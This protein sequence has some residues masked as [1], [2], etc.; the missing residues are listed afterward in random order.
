MYKD[1]GRSCFFSY[2]LLQAFTGRIIMNLDISLKDSE[3][4]QAQLK[5]S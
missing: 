4:H 2:Y 3:G 5:C 1:Y